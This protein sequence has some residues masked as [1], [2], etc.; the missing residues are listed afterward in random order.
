MQQEMLVVSP[1][2]GRLAG[3]VLTNTLPA[4]TPRDQPIKRSTAVLST[5][6]RE[7]PDQPAVKTIRLEIVNPFQYEA[8]AGPMEIDY[9]AQ[10]SPPAGSAAIRFRSPSAP[11]QPG[12]QLRLYGAPRNAPEEAAELHELAVRT[13]AKEK[14]QMH[15]KLEDHSAQLK[16]FKEQ[17]IK[18]QQVT[19]A[20]NR[21]VGDLTSQLHISTQQNGELQQQLKAVQAA[22]EAR[23]AGLEGS[24]T[25]NNTKLDAM[26]DTVTAVQT[27]HKDLKKS[28]EHYADAAISQDVMAADRGSNAWQPHGEAS[29]S[30]RDDPHSYMVR[31]VNRDRGSIA[32]ADAN[33]TT[34]I[35]VQGDSNIMAEFSKVGTKSMSEAIAAKDN[36][37]IAA[38]LVECVHGGLGHQAEWVVKDAT[39]HEPSKT[40]IIEHYPDWGEP[41]RRSIL[42]YRLK[43]KLQLSIRRA[44][45]KHERLVKQQLQPTYAWLYEQ[46]KGKKPVGS[47]TGSLKLVEQL[48]WNNC[49]IWVRWQDEKEFVEYASGKFMVGGAL[50]SGFPLIDFA[51]MRE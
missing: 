33:D 43:H 51:G 26:A 6:S 13:A 36:V 2:G 46:M 30:G 21:K 29:T 3:R 27:D 38:A 24:V 7:L 41:V 23:L 50:R 34:V 49:R 5:A 11:R 9:A 39:Y 18:Q 25:A 48:R 31:M 8:N 4:I 1:G 15:S 47:G 28:C 12:G 37:K 42:A 40:F 16:E 14:L 19:D 22:L 45:T 10:A 35:R 17:R 32:W 44:L 20:L